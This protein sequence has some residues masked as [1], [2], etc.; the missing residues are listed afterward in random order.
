M[1]FYADGYYSYSDVTDEDATR[2][3]AFLL[4][5]NHSFGITVHY[6]M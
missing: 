1:I 6:G 3:P 4:G 2:T 5:K